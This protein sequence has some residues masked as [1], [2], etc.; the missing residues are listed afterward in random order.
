ISQDKFANDTNK[1]LKEIQSNV[2]DLNNRVENLEQG[3]TGEFQAAQAFSKGDHSKLQL[4]YRRLIDKPNVA[5]LYSGSRVV[6]SSPAYS[7]VKRTLFTRF[8]NAFGVGLN[9]VS[10]PSFILQELGQMGKCYP[11][12]VNKNKANDFGH[13][14]IRLGRAVPVAG[15]S[16]AHIGGNETLDFTSAPKDFTVTCINAERGKGKN[17]QD[18]LIVPQNTADRVAEYQSNGNVYQIFDAKPTDGENTEGQ[19]TY[20]TCTHVRFD[21]LSNYGN[22][23]YTCIYHIEV[24]TPKATKAPQSDSK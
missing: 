22:Q 16:I 2:A 8:K 7:P 6:G 14:T 17:R 13:I 15:V 5:Y 12:K 18:S 24:Y 23:D 1:N 9:Y 11:L 20:G 10:K 4:Y 21:F 3:R 19:H